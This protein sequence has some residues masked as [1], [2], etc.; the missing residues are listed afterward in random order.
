ME[1]SI[2]VNTNQNCALVGKWDCTIMLRNNKLQWT[3]DKY[4]YKF[5]VTQSHFIIGTI[6]N[7][8]QLYG[9]FRTQHLCIA[10]ARKQIEKIAKDPRAHRHH[11]IAAGMVK[12]N[13]EVTEWESEGFGVKTPPERQQEIQTIVTELYQFGKLTPL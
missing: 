9:V 12:A 2:F 13:G 11:I 6:S 10:E 7:H 4:A 5:V 3:S 1:V 8:S